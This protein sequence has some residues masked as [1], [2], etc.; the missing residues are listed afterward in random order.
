[1]DVFRVVVSGSFASGR[2]GRCKWGLAYFRHLL[3]VLAAHGLELAMMGA[4]GGL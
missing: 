1:M 4:K 3:R 2:G